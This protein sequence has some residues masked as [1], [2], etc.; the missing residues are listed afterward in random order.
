[1]RNKENILLAGGGGHCKVVID[2]IERAGFYNIFGIVDPGIR[3]GDNVLGIPVI[4]DDGALSGFFKRGIRYAFISVGSVA[5]CNARKTLYKKLKDIGFDLPVIIHPKAVVAPDVKIGEGTFIAASSAVNPGTVIGKNVILN[6]RSS[7]DHDCVIDDFVHIAPGVTLSGG[8]KIGSGTHVGTGASVTQYLK[9]GKDCVIGAGTT[10][11]HDMKK[12]SRN[13]GMD[14]RPL[15][16]RKVFIIA[17]AG[18]NHNG[19]RETARK[20]IDAAKKAGA[21]AIKFQTFRAEGIARKSAPKADYQKK[22]TSGKESHFAMLKRLELDQNDHRSLLAYCRKKRIKFLSSPFDEKSIDMLVKLGLQIFKVPSGEI[23]NLPYLR[24][25][26][27][28]KKSVILSTGMSDM[29]EIE[30]ALSALIKSGTPKDNITVLQCSTEYPA[31]Y[32]DVNLLAMLTIK[33]AFKVNVGYSDHAAGPEAAI[34][35]AALGA[36]VIEK[37][38]TLDKNMPGPDHKASLEPGEFS[39]MVKALRNVEK[40]LGDGTKRV[41]RSEEKNKPITRKSIV[42]AKRIKKGERFTVKNI[43]AKRPATGISCSFWES[44][45]GKTAKKDFKKDGFIQL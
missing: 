38:F 23:T 14:A 37:H 25:I 26:G 29:E 40:A 22:T 35:A 17:E 36:G 7:V 5:N 28:L 8:V 32:K 6:T 15:K 39:L 20:M 33:N 2:A 31:P 12:K 16:R 41:S 1:M 45:V 34:A 10:L 18:V 13:F 42:A 30:K 27:G 11:R 3:K 21:D 44:V 24:K 43:T 9:I 19:S 4:G